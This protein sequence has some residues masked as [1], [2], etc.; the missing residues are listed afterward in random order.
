MGKAARSLQRERE[1][2]SDSQILRYSRLQRVHESIRNGRQPRALQKTRTS[3][4]VWLSYA[5]KVAGLSSKGTFD[6]NFPD[7][8][9]CWRFF[10]TASPYFLGL[11]GRFTFGH[12]LL[13]TASKV[14]SCTD[15]VIFTVRWEKADG[16]DGP[17]GTLLSFRS[18]NQTSLC[19]LS[20]L[21]PLSG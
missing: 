12:G 20:P 18:V 2:D 5:T 3:R 9:L 17:L 1:R 15:G 13:L 7:R 10:P 14:P 21:L 11:F 6:Y 8:L 16:T 19:L 4:R